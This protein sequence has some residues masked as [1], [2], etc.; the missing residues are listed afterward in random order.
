[1]KFTSTIFI[2]WILA[3]PTQ[4]PMGSQ[5]VVLWNVGQGQWVTLLTPSHCLHIDMGGEIYPRPV[6]ALCQHRDN[7]LWLTHMDW[8][9]IS[10]VAPFSRRMKR[11]CLASPL[12]KQSRR[13]RFIHSLGLTR[14]KTPSP[15]V[16]KL[17]FPLKKAHSPND[18]SGVYVLSKQIL[19]PGDSTKK[20]EL[21]WS[22][23]LYAWPN[24]HTLVA[25]HHGSLSSTSSQLLHWLP[26]LQQ[27]LV[28]AR[29]VKYGHPHPRVLARLMQR[30]L[31]V[32]TTENKGHIFV[33]IKGKIQSPY[34]RKWD[35]ED[36]GL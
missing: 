36:M 27:V 20:M 30:G 24:I 12:L 19:I 2:V 17:S 31:T 15:Q 21:L 10:W 4:G 13:Y 7:Q 22:P 16:Q 25:G 1:M 3:L 6:D 26:R 18:R 11:L 32:L 35:Y 33:E 29:R 34:H 8:D 5:K 28:S 23:Q 14:C 9:H